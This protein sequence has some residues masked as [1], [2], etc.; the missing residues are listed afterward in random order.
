VQGRARRDADHG[1]A[2][3]RHERGQRRLGDE[4]RRPQVARELGLELLHRRRGDGLARREA[5]G[6][7]DHGLERRARAPGRGRDDP[8]DVA[9]VREIG[10]HHLGAGELLLG[11]GGDHD[12]P[13][14]GGEG[15]DDGAPEAARPT[16]D[17]RGA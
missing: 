10:L 8:G 2:A 14:V 7:V 3:G 9:G 11:P 5:A 6:E 1:A 17:E 12:V 15:G 13:A 16:R 4:V